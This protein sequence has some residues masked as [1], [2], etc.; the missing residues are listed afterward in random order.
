MTMSQLVDEVV[1]RGAD[2]S[3]VISRLRHWVREGLI[4]PEGEPHPGSG[5]HRSFE[6]SALMVALALN[7]L[8]DFNLPVGALRAAARELHREAL[9]R[10]QVRAP[11]LFLV[12]GRADSGKLGAGVYEDKIPASDRFLVLDL[13]QIWG[14]PNG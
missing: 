14:P 1:R 7:A 4:E 3:L 13:T 9:P 11:Q 8:A 6:D 2:K 12:M 10:W 5:R